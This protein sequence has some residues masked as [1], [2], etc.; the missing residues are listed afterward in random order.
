M[1]RLHFHALC[2][3]RFA[4]LPLLAMAVNAC[5]TIPGEAMKPADKQDFAERYAQAWSS[6]DPHSVA[7]FFEPDG[8]LKV[9]DD[10]PAVGRK[11]IEDVA[12]GFMTAFPDIVVNFDR[13]GRDESRT[14]FHWTLT[15]HNTGPD[16]TGNF[17]KVSGVESWMFGPDDLVASSIGH[18]DAGE[19][20][21]QLAGD[22]GAKAEILA[23][24]DKWVAA[25]IAGDAKALKDILDKR[26][27]HT[28]ASGK[29]VDRK[30][31]IDYITELEIGP[32]TVEVDRIILHG[33][34]AVV[35]D[36]LGSTK[37]TWI[38]VRKS[39]GWR[40]ISQTF[41]RIKSEAK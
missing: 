5:A 16:G 4:I 24:Q 37:I 22:E 10:P 17:V 26:F 32:F 23:L 29:T 15:G 33:D 35:I 36:E 21:R 8:S 40:A 38:A 20:D 1:K 41:T 27:V 9:N 28:F 11:A 18:F 7:L 3:A 34:T 14:L 25:E 13:L 30:G 31:Y 6:Q 19:Y 39:K 2:M 12:R